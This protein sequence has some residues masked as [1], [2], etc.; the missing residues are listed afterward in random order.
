MLNKPCLHLREPEVAA[1]MRVTGLEIVERYPVTR[2]HVWRTMAGAQI[3]DPHQH[4][5]NLDW[6]TGFDFGIYHRF[7]VASPDADGKLFIYP[8]LDW[9]QGIE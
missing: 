8:M 3:L 6:N 2:S 9:V 4:I 7:G 1:L 5:I